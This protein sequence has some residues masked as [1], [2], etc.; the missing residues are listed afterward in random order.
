MSG[1]DDVRRASRRRSE[2]STA[3]TYRGKSAAD[4]SR[5]RALG[6]SM[7]I[8]VIGR[9]LHRIQQFDALQIE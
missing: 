5:Y 8:P 7:A 1:F 6:N 3:I 4:G 9:I 2:M